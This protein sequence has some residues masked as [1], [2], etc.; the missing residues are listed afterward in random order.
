MIQRPSYLSPYRHPER[1]MER[2]NL[3][4]DSMVETGAITTDEADARKATPL[5][6]APP[7]VEASDAP[8]FVDLV[9]DQLTARFNERDM[10][11][12]GYRIYT[13]VDPE[14]AARGSRCGAGRHQDR[15]RARREAAHAQDQDRQR[16]GREGRETKMSP[17]PV[18]QVALVAIDPHTGDVLALV[19]G[20]NYGFSQLN[21]AVAKRPTGSIF[22]PFVYAAAMNT[23][24]EQGTDP[25]IT[26]ASLVDDS[27]TTFT[28]GDQIYE[29]RNYKEEYHGQ[30]SATYALAHSLN[31][32]TVKVAEMT[33]L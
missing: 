3:V 30:V 32:A 31:N 23:R 25:V 6:L 22:K 20:R 7:N 27:P 18:P 8:Y 26:P 21:H 1:A 15:R 2:R 14:S 33:G 10:N 24:A 11:E 4:L 19:G 28:Y 13:T 16:Q 29:P 12:Q 17:G 9:K 5:K